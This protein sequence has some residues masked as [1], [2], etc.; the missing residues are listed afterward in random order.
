MPG[1]MSIWRGPVVVSRAA[2]EAKGLHVMHIRQIILVLLWYGQIG[3]AYPVMV[4][5]RV[6]FLICLSC[7]F[8]I[9]DL[10]R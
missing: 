8:V 2:M 7:C 6:L 10:G 5:H 9:K 4:K 3:N 1:L